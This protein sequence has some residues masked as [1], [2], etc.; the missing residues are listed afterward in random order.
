MSTVAFPL[1]EKLVENGAPM[2]K[3]NIVVLGEGF[4]VSE[5]AIFDN[6]ADL[7]AV[8]LLEYETLRGRGR[9]HQR[10]ESV[11]AVHG[12]RRHAARP[13][14]EH[15]L[16]GRGE[17]AERGLSR[18]LRHPTPGA[19]HRRGRPGRPRRSAGRQDLDRQ[20]R[21]RRRPGLPRG[22]HGV[23]AAVQGRRQGST[24]SR[25]RFESGTSWRSTV[26]EC[27]H[28]IADLAEEYISCRRA[29]GGG[30]APQPADARGDGS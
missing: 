25:R 1:V 22:Q 30:G 5:L 9:A 28:A 3:F 13:A 10:V 11:D 24:P 21:R 6:Y 29:R 16:R 2:D 20:P 14:Q 19:G 4:K 26:H 18:V 7:I 27:G 15:L 8:R 23:R 12:F 17:L